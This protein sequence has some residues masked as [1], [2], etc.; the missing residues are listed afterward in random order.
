MKRSILGSAFAIILMGASAAV[1][2][3]RL[4]LEQRLHTMPDSTVVTFA[5]RTL[6]LGKLRAAHHARELHL[7]VANQTGARAK[8]RLV[9][10]LIRISGTSTTLPTTGPTPKPI[11]RAVALRY[12][13]QPGSLPTATPRP[14]YKINLGGLSKIGVVEP[15][16]AYASTPA[17]MRGFCSA[18]WA[19]ACLYLPP[20]QVGLATLPGEGN[21]DDFDTLIDQTQCETEGGWWEGW[22]YC[23]FRYPTSYQARFT[24]TANFALAQTVQCDQTIWDYVVDVHGAISIQIKPRLVSSSDPDVSLTTFSSGLAPWCIIHVYPGR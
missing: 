24:P 17:D 1:P 13:I 16:S 4:S 20:Q 11:S 15:A 10:H 21:I 3:S 9:A 22:G 14:G 19:S 18:A 7:T 12:G 5:G 6:T 23:H 2:L 8:K